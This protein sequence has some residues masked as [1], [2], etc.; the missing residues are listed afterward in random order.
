MAVRAKT[1]IQIEIKM[2]GASCRGRN[3]M[4]EGRVEYLL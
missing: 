4:Y 2:E 1:G 3:E